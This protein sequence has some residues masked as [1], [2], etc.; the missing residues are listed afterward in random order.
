MLGKRRAL[1]MGSLLVAD[2]TTL[3]LAFLA[4]H[5]LRVLLN[6]PLGRPAGPLGHYLWLLVPILPVWVTLL[7][8]RGGYGLHWTTG[9]RLALALWPNLAGL[10]ILSTGLFFSQEQEVNRSLLMLFAATAALGLWM[11]R[12][13]VRAWRRRATPWRRH[14]LVVGTGDPARHLVSALVRYPEAGWL[15]QGCVVPDPTEASLAP[16]G[17]PV[18]GA[19][20]DLAE[21][22]QGEQVID[23]VFFA[24]GPGRLD[25]LVDALETCESLGVD[26]RVMVDVHRSLHARPFVEELFGLPFYGFSPTLTR[27]G[28]LGVK[29]ALDVVGALG[30]LLVTWP[31][32][33]LIAVLVRAT[34]RGPVLFVQERAGFHGRRFRMFKFRTMIEGAEA[35]QAEL[36]HLNRMSGPVFKAL[37]DPRVTPLGRL[38]RRTSLDELPQLWN[39]L[40]GDMS[41]VGPRPLPV[42]ETRQIRGAQRRRLAMRP[43]ITGSWQASGRSTLDFADWMRLDLEYVDRWSLWLDFRIL[44]RTIPAVLRGEGAA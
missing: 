44:F 36:A 23:E 41:L 30:L 28:A 4:A 19:L 14:A 11:E 16:A 20:A 13:L 29:R 5:G 12:G 25:G 9:S 40:R 27:Q 31:L 3:V 7:A 6:V 21:I 22:L 17:L 35:R 39:V 43:G 37:D 34:S 10:A 1:W 42:S 24:L 8:L 15:V 2:A 32:A 18:V 33:L 38:L 26:A